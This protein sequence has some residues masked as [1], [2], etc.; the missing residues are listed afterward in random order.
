MA[1]IL[2]KSFNVQYVLD[3]HW[4]VLFLFFQSFH[5]AK[6]WISFTENNKNEGQWNR[7]SKVVRRSMEWREADTKSSPKSF[8]YSSSSPTPDTPEGSGWIIVVS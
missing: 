1:Q 5:D 3:Y 7:G 4:V 2:C 8:P 6:R